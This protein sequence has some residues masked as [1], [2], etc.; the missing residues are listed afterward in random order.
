[1]TRNL[2]FVLPDTLAVEALQ[3]MVQG[4]TKYQS[5]LLLSK[6]FKK[7]SKVIASHDIEKCL[8]DAIAHIERAA[9]KGKAIAAAIEG[10]EKFQVNVRRIF[11]ASSKMML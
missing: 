1:M 6:P 5:S 10:V 4:C 11:R 2:V 8:Y 9:E 7:W 3:K